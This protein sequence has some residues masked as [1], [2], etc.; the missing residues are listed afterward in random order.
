MKIKLYFGDED[1]IKKSGIGRALVHQ[2]KALELN[3]IEYTHDTNATDY[4]ILHINTIFPSSPGE[5]RKA[6]KLGKKVVYHAHS[7]AEDFGGSFMMSDALTPLYKKWLLSLYGKADVL[8]TPTPYSKK[9]IE[10]YGL[11]KKVFAISNGVDLDDFNPTPE[12]IQAFKDYF[13]ITDEKVI[14]SV[15]WLFE[16]KGFDTFCEVALALP[17]YKFIWFG[18]VT[19]SNPT[20][21]IRKYLHHLP[22]NV[23]LPGYVEG[24]VIK[25]AY[26]G[27]DVFFFPSREETEGIV[28]LEA[29]AAKAN[30]ILRD[31]SVYDEWLI[32]KK[33]VYK[34]KTNDDFIRLI[35]GLVNG[36]LPSLKE[37]GYKVAQARNL[38]TIGKE[39][40]EVYEYVMASGEHL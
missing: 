29:L 9:L 37:E 19:L 17:R 16:R 15:G 13:H 26:G 2:M 22:S 21:K 36:S 25:G 5:V 18:D 20:R 40:K 23:I 1:K 14:M 28:V 3:G 8:I 7:T 6:R 35:N 30:I 31:I 12:Q 33:S 38:E 4:D 10:S 27:A 24:D 11:N 34:G 32:N 39:L